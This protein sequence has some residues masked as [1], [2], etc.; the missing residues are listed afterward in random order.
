MLLKSAGPERLETLRGVEG[1][2]VEEVRI[3]DLPVGAIVRAET[4]TKNVYLLE[5]V[6]PM[7]RQMGVVRC[8]PRPGC[9]STGYRG[10]RHISSL[11]RI[12]QQIRHDNAHTSPVTR[13]TLILN[14]EMALTQ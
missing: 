12:G 2:S 1:K 8:E 4:E 9:P 7:L 3:T 13:L 10:V 11:V 5:A 6:S 14:P